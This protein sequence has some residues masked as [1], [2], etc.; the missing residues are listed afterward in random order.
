MPI[1]TI[2]FYRSESGVCPLENFLNTLSAKQAQKITWV[3]QLV[4][5][6][7]VVPAQYFKKLVGSDDFWEVRVQVGNNIIRLL[8]FLE[9]DKVVILNHA[10]QKKTQKTPKR[11]I[12]IAEARKRDYLKRRV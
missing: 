7:D 6:M 10:F 1:R 5:D 12:Q 3:L 9:N 2:N 8:G 11:E 4:E